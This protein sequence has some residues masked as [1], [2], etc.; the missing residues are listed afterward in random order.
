MAV[1]LLL[2]H[3]VRHF[4]EQDPVFPLNLSVAIL[5]HLRLLKLLLQVVILMR[6][7]NLQLRLHV[8]QLFLVD[9][10]LL[11]APPPRQELVTLWN[12]SVHAFTIKF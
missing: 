9:L 7:L 11:L 10:P 6:L 12:G 3:Y 8:D 5:L 4:L 1:L 2:L